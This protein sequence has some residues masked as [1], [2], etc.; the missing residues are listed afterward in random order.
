MFDEKTKKEVEEM[1]SSEI[2]KQMMNL[3]GDDEILATVA[4][5][6]KRIDKVYLDLE[7]T[8]DML[9]QN[10]DVVHEINDMLKNMDLSV[11]EVDVKP[12]LPKDSPMVSTQVEKK[13]EFKKQLEETVEETD[14][15]VELEWTKEQ[16]GDIEKGETQ[17][18][19]YGEHT[20]TVW[21]EK[22]KTF[23]QVNDDVAT[24]LYRQKDLEKLQ[25]LI[26]K[27]PQ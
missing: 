8:R 26:E 22:N 25:K 27:M 23:A 3:V 10:I 5:V 7:A 11:I 2:K 15:N 12:V 6:S 13:P 17:I 14:E 21:K 19:N 9:R 24:E 16:D 18:W 20:L 1:V 4:Q